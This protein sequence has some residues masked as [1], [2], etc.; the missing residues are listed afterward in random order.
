[1]AVKLGRKAILIELKPSYFEVLVRNMQA[2]EAQ[3]T[4][5]DLFTWA[6]Q[7]AEMEA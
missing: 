1:M 2:I 4:I 6:E 3:T 7:Q 5:P